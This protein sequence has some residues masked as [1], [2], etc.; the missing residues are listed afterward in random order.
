MIKMSIVKLLT[1]LCL[2]AFPGDQ[3]PVAFDKVLDLVPGASGRGPELRLFKH[4]FYAT[5]AKGIG[6][7]SDLGDMKRRN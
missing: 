7:T 2:R 4:Q 3:G 1:A 5:K 6:L